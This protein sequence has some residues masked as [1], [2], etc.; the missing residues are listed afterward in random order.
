MEVD[1]NKNVSL[2]LTLGH[3]I[4]IRELFANKLSGSPGNGEFTE[5]E[6]RAVWALE[7]L[8]DNEI[9]KNTPREDVP[10]DWNKLVNQAVEFVKSIPVE[11]TE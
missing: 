1:L 5:E 11:Y 3:L 7:D 10:G 6:K 9:A 4:V 8:C 2:E